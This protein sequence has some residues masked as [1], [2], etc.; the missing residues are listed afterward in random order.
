MTQSIKISAI[1]C[2]RNR[3][4]L[5][6]KAIDS[7]LHQTLDNS[8]FEIII[9]DNAS[10][11]GTKR[12][13]ESYKSLHNFQYI[14]EPVPGLSI[15]RNAGVRA[16]KGEYVAF[17]DDD[18]IASPKWLESIVNDFERVSPSPES[19]GGKIIPIWEAPKP[20]WFPDQL[21]PYLTILDH[22]GVP[23]FLK[24]PEILF[25]T[26]MSFRKSTLQNIGGFAPYF[27]RVKSKLISCEET[28]VFKKFN[29]NGYLIWYN[30]DAYVSHLIPQNRSTKKYIY[31]RHYWQARS[32]VLLLQG[33]YPIEKIFREILYSIKEIIKCTVKIIAAFI[34]NYNSQ[35]RLLIIACTF[36]RCGRLIGWILNLLNHIF[37]GKVVPNTLK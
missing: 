12:V 3:S 7:L 26:N 33:E 18:A 30:P 8:K 13:C 36:D 28:E 21:N 15:S 27:G 5:L 34:K 37:R 14:Y 17:I 19:V 2:T 1:I 22:G 25:G 9:V 20:E 23:M 11:D 31:V 6:P 29:V 35:N 32:Q 16:A 10:E 4:D 24:Y